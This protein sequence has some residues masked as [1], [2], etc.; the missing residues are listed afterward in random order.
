MKS[1]SFRV[2]TSGKVEIV[3]ITDEVHLALD[4]LGAG[5]GLCTIFTPHTT[6]A[7][8]VNENADPDVPLDLC[9]ALR[10]MVPDVRFDHGEGNSDA[11]LLSTLIGPSVV[12]PCRGGRL[13][14]GRWQGVYFI[15]LDG[16]RTREVRVHVVG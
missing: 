15:E 14:L 5:E 1:T 2:K 6:A 11:H 16:P 7:V 3:I 4:R 8:S 13:A 12:V 9:R 10:A